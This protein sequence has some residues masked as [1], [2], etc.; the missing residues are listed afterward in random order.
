[1]TSELLQVRE[2][3]VHYAV[4]SGIFGKARD[5]VRA[6]DGVTFGLSEG[7]VL[8]IVGESGCG[9]TTL[10]RA[11]LN[12]VKPTS[13]AVYFAGRAVASVR[14]E[15]LRRFRR[16]TGIVFQD[17][18]SSLDPRMSVRDI[19]GEPLRVHRL[20][21]GSAY[22]QRVLELLLSVGLEA[23]MARRYPHEFSGGQRQRIG[24]ARALASR[25]RFIVCDEPTSA[26]DVSVRLQIVE[27]LKELRRTEN[28]TLLFIS[29]DLATVRSVADRIAVMYLGK[30]V[31]SGSAEQVIESP[32]HPYT[33][34]LLAACLEPDPVF[35]RSRSMPLLI[36][37]PPSARKIPPGCAFHPRCPSAKVTR[38]AEGEIV[39]G[40][41]L[42]AQELQPAID[43]TGHVACWQ[44]Q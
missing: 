36:G 9:K 11:V 43:G 3:S 35:E 13:G 44:E 10:G 8:G 15:R 38:D 23:S 2:L 5:V 14:G 16:E 7:E 42:E 29:H 4:R 6:L 31:E 37:D 21:E 30:I 18:F 1:M 24:I 17:P 27:L 12:L 25:P 39:G 19:V 41:C 32:R 22:D 40:P 20:A 28:L 34:Q 26:L 33:R